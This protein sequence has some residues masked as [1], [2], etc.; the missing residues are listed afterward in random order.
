MQDWKDVLVELFWWL[1]FWAFCALITGTAVVAVV[2][3]TD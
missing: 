3:L 1:I 2:N